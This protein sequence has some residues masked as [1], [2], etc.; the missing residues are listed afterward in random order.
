MHLSQHKII[1]NTLIFFLLSRVLWC[2]HHY[3]WNPSINCQWPRI[4]F[5]P[6]LHY[7]SEPA[8][9]K[10]TPDNNEMDRGKEGEKMGRGRERKRNDGIILSLKL[11]LLGALFPG[12]FSFLLR[13]FFVS[14]CQPR[15][16]RQ[17]FH[18]QSH[19]HILYSRAR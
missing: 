5:T 17:N 18:I 2:G 9:K 15:T 19:D 10:S 7:Q 14:A 4:P 11:D 16:K 1:S 3:R 6:L 12:G 13:S 8:A